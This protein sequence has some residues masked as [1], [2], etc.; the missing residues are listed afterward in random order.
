MKCSKISKILP[1]IMLLSCAHYTIYNV[2]LLGCFI[3]ITA[4]PIQSDYREYWIKI[5]YCSFSGPS[6]TQLAIK[7][8]S[9]FITYV[10]LFIVCF[11]LLKRSYQNVTLCSLLYCSSKLQIVSDTFFAYINYTFQFNYFYLLRRWLPW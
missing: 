6:A 4:L 9:I 5:L 1:P 11:R 7:C 8:Q 2:I 3:S 10:Q